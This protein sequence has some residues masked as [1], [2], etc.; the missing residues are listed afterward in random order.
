[1][2]H[3]Y[4][5]SISG[6]SW[7]VQNWEVTLSLPSEGAQSGP[8]GRWQFSSAHFS[9]AA[10]VVALVGSGGCEVWNE[11]DCVSFRTWPDGW[12]TAVWSGM[13]GDTGCVAPRVQQ[14]MLEN[15]VNDSIERRYGNPAFV[16]KH[17]WFS[18]G[19]GRERRS[20]ERSKHMCISANAEE[21]KRQMD[22]T[23]R[24]NLKVSAMGMSWW[25]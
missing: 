9:S 2:G 16:I 5:S 11:W 19:W 13:W 12:F 8:P 21:S 17:G 24:G 10:S 4:V 1:M 18:R 20:G 25:G 6:R 15:Y 23:G 3:L 14:E 22:W 7:G